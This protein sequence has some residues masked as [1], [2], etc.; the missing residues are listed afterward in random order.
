M[1]LPIA[2]GLLLLGSLVSTEVHASRAREL[3]LGTGDAGVALNGGSF[4]FDHGYNIFYNPAYINDFNHWG[5]IEKS[6][7]PGGTAQGGI[8]D[9]LF[10]ISYG[11][12]L[13]RGS[14]IVTVPGIAGG[15]TLPYAVA[16]VRPFE[17]FVGGDFG[18][19]WGLGLSYAGARASS[20]NSS[21]LSVHAGAVIGDYE[22]FFTIKPSGNEPNREHYFYRAGLRYRWGEW[23]PYFVAVTAGDRSTDPNA[24]SALKEI[25]Y[26]F[27][28]TRST[29]V[30]EGV[31][32]NYGLSYYKIADSG[33]PAQGERKILP[34]DLS[35]EG[36]LNEWATLLG[37][38]SYR[39]LDR[40]DGLSSADNTTGR[41]GL[42]LAND[43][44]SLEWALGKNLPD[45]GSEQPDSLDTQSIDLTNGFFTAANVTFRW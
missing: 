17:F 25:T 23:V 16:P 33:G 2:S 4:L 19:K 44:V 40:L 26:G 20:G 28:F 39:L 29:R 32:M 37:G 24:L 30:V 10:L 31:K 38:V 22:P 11:V 7:A 45:N 12:F 9:S 34:L 15:T 6:N 5:T 8:F 27:G 1:K 35:F 18:F 21:D 41:I 3:I 13:N 43:K 42:R 36:A 14:A